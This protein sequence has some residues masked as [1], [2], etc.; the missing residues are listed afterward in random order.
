MQ[1]RVSYIG[2]VRIRVLAQ[3]QFRNVAVAAVAGKNQGA[4]DGGGMAPVRILFSTFSHTFAPGATS[5][6]A[7]RSNVSPAVRNRSLWQVTQY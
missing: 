6:T 7:I 2:G 5:S 1:C 3:Q 4:Q